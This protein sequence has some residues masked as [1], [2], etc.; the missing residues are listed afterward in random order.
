MSIEYVQSDTVILQQLG[1]GLAKSRLQLQLTQAELAEQAGVSKRTVERIEAGEPAQTDNLIRILRV[2][3][4]L[5]N[6][7]QLIPEAHLRPFEVLQLKGKERRRAS[8]KKTSRG[9]GDDQWSWGDEK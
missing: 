3:G 5:E 9:A 2:L 6:L 1:R 8:G 7:S 4:L